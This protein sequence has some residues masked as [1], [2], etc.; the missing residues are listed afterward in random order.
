M[1]RPLKIRMATLGYTYYLSPVAYGDVSGKPYMLSAADGEAPTV[2]RII[3]SSASF[4]QFKTI[5]F[6]TGEA[7]DTTA[8]TDGNFASFDGISTTG[9]TVGSTAIRPGQEAHAQITLPGNPGKL[10]AYIETEGGWVIFTQDSAVAGVIIRYVFLEGFEIQSSVLG[11][12]FSDAPAY[13]FS[14]ASVGVKIHSPRSMSLLLNHVEVTRMDERVLTS[15]ILRV[16]WGAGMVTNTSPAYI[17]YPTRIYNNRTYGMRPLRVVIVGD[18]TADKANPICMVNHM[19]RCASGVG[20]LQF[21]TILNQAVS[22]HTAKQQRDVV[23]ATDYQAL[24]GF[25]YMLIDVG[26]N[27]IGGGSTQQEFIDAIVDIIHRCE[28]FGITPLVGIPA[29]FYDQTS[30]TPYGQIG[31]GTAN[32]DRGAPYRLQLL[33]KLSELSVQA[34]MLPIQDMGAI[35]PSML[36]NPEL[37]PM[38]Q[39]NVHQSNFGAEL[40]GAAWAKAL[41]GYIYSRVRK[42]IGYRSIKVAWIE[43]SKRPTYGNIARPAFGILED[44]FFMGNSMNIPAMTASPEVPP[45]GTKLFRL[46]QTY[47]PQKQRFIWHPAGATNGVWTTQVLLRYDADGWVYSQTPVNGVVFV[48]FSSATWPLPK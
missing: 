47:A 46:P 20:G 26:I 7:T 4:M 12:P 30:A 42:D 36:D 17:S 29:L 22:G 33:R 23:Y 41:I 15:D 3:T 9:F 8:S 25:D 43:T 10:C 21:K 2:E 37:N 24:G 32:A 19:R 27:D 28:L 34:V 6:S 31:V 18:S 11:L 16:G 38:V 45:Y 5:N 40:K 48:D 14:A 35:L 44:T 1:V 39:D 13:N